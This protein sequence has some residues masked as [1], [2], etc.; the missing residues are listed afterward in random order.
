[1]GFFVSFVQINQRFPDT[2][3][4]NVPIEESGKP[5]IDN[6]RQRTFNETVEFGEHDVVLGMKRQE[7][8][9]RWCGG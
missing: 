8:E 7:V 4:G 3:I 6:A 2:E 9:R 1:M 5:R